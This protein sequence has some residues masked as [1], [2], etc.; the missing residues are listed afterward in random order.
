MQSK[1]PK[2]T[3]I[4]WPELE[5]LSLANEAL[6]PPLA[7]LRPRGID[8]RSHV[9]QLEALQPGDLVL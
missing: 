3:F 2:I 8:D 4:K 1:N 9:L 5:P 6:V 7:Q